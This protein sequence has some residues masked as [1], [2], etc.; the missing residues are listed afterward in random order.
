MEINLI[1]TCYNKEEYLLGLLECINNYKKLKVNVCISYN[2]KLDSFPC[3]IKLTNNGHQ[4]GD[5]ELTLAG[6]SKLK[7]N[8]ITRFIKIAI[9]SWLMDEN[10]IIEIFKGLENNKSA[11][12]GNY[13]FSEN[14]ASL[15]TDI[16]FADIRYGDIFENF[17]WD[18][19]YFESSLYQTIKKNNFKV[20]FINERIPANPT[21]RFDCEKLNWT[22]SHSILDNLDKLWK[23]KK[24][25]NSIQAN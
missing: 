15:A 3:D 1:V 19:L 10:V 4:I 23:F 9:D 7:T 11:Y 13:W 6:Y 18:G 20:S 16:I 24:R 14:S 12:G 22:M 2:G 8:G 25:I 21:Y 17:T 5:I